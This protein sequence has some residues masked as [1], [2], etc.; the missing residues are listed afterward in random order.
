MTW[1]HC[2]KKFALYTCKHIVKN[3]M[4]LRRNLYW[5]IEITLEYL[6]GNDRLE[7]K[8]CVAAGDCDRLLEEHQELNPG[9]PE[10]QELLLQQLANRQCWE[11]VSLLVTGEHAGPRSS[12]DFSTPNCSATK[13]SVGS[14]LQDL[15]TRDLRR[16]GMHL[17]LA[18]IKNGAPIQDIERKWGIPVLHVV[19]IKTLETGTVYCNHI[20]VK[21]FI[22]ND[23]KVCSTWNIK[24]KSFIGV[25]AL[26]KFLFRKYL[27]TQEKKNTVDQYGRCV[28]HII[29]SFRSCSED[30]RNPLLLLCL[31]NGCNSFIF[32]NTGNLPID[33]CEAEDKCYYSLSRMFMDTGLFLWEKKIAYVIKQ[34]KI[35]SSISFSLI[36]PASDYSFAIHLLRIWIRYKLTAIILFWYRNS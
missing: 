14:L 28:L 12:L 34:N 19:S 25:D 3:I 13:L 36:W 5:V 27:N 35:H 26:V 18:L 24:T 32:D 17:A 1:M 7:Y 6:N 20:I 22:W 11:G 33:F 2:V 16:Y 9:P 30:E 4:P 29:A 21:K 10:V 23:K 15:S 31:N 8:I